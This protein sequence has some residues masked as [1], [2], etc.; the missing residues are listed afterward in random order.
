LHT[1]CLADPSQFAA[2]PGAAAALARLKSES[3]WAV[4]L[5]TG[6]WR[7]SALIKLRAADIGVDSIPAAFADD[8]IAREDILQLAIVK[9]LGHCGQNEFEKIV[10]IGDAVWDVHTAVKLKVAFL[11]IGRGES[12]ARLR[13][14]GARQVIDDFTDLDRFMQSLDEAEIPETTGAS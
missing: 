7:P 4:A 6:S 11:G 9:A 10:S 2:I 5:A 13:H 1:C 3:G 14:A 12:V 8:G